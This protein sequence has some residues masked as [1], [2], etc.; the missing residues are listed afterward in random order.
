MISNVS[1]I[2]K[3]DLGCQNIRQ[4]NDRLLIDKFDI[5]DLGW[6]A[7]GRGGVGWKIWGGIYTIERQLLGFSLKKF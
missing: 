2:E 4:V 3:Q 5:Q 1:T 7:S 6:A